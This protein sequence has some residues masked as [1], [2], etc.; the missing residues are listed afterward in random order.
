MYIFLCSLSDMC[1][2]Q[3]A[4]SLVGLRS[5]NAADEKIDVFSPSASVVRLASASLWPCELLEI[6]HAYLYFTRDAFLFK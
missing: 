4:E 6:G 3:Q 1:E 5:G 2:H